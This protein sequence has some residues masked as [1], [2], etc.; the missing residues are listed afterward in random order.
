MKYLRP[1]ALL[2]PLLLAA[3]V[4]SPEE[5][6]APP[7]QTALFELLV[8]TATADAA[9]PAA[10]FSAPRGTP[11]AGAPTPDDCTLQAA[12]VRD[13]TIPDHTVM[14]PGEQFVKAWQMRN[15]GTCDWSGGVVIVHTDGDR[16]ATAEAYAVAA[17]PSGSEVE[18][19]V[20]MRAPA[21]PGTY[22]SYWRLATDDGT[23]FGPGVYA[24]I[25]VQ[26]PTP[27]P[28]STPSPGPTSTAAPSPTPTRTPC[29]IAASF[30]GDVTIPDDTAL[31][32]AETFLKTWR[33]RNSGACEWPAGTAL[34]H[35]EGVRM[36]NGIDALEEPVPVGETVDV[37]VPMRA[38]AEPGTHVERFRLC[39]QGG[40]CFGPTVYVR[41]V[42]RKA[43]LFGPAKSPTP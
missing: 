4:M 16:L 22:R 35:V 12:Y 9:D 27:G 38:P 5:L 33:M 3:C 1:A 32:P 10:T 19:A 17:A 24:A 11:P 29:R 18:I 30:L 13:L 40:V 36:A 6:S 15:T 34:R 28:T 41:I 37:A 2:L 42:V 26:E 31:R 43:D 21:E 14:S 25:V 39:D 23:A 8:S 7:M 20:P